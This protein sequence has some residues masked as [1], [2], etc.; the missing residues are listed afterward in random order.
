[1]VRLYIKISSEFVDRV[2]KI[3][4]MNSVQFENYGRFFQDI[5]DDFRSVDEL[6]LFRLSLY[7]VYKTK[8]KI[9]FVKKTEEINWEVFCYEWFCLDSPVIP[10]DNNILAQCLPLYI[11]KKYFFYD[12]F[13]RKLFPVCDL[14][15]HLY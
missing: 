14:A 2:D 7:N 8:V 12:S 10:V 3:S 1:M 6:N 9:G 4:K 5:L 13:Y 15:Y 11:R